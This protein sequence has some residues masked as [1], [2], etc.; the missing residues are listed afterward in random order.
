MVV[1]LALIAVTT[2]GV[3]WF[4]RWQGRQAEFRRRVDALQ[5]LVAGG[6]RTEAAALLAEYKAKSPDTFNAPEIQALAG[7]LGVLEQRERDR[8]AAR[9]RTLASIQAAIDEGTWPRLEFAM[10]EIAEAEKLCTT[11]VERR[12][13]QDLLARL[14]SGIRQHQ[15]A[16][17]AEF[18][19]LL[20]ELGGRVARVSGSDR[21]TLAA[22]RSE[23]ENLSNM[24]RVAPELRRQTQPLIERLS[25]LAKGQSAREQEEQALALVT[26]SIGNLGNYVAA[27]DGYAKSFPQ[28]ARAAAFTR[29][30]PDE[31]PLW[32]AVEPWNRVV[33]RWS[34]QDYRKLR[35]EEAKALLMEMDAAAMTHGAFPAA[36]QLQAVRPYLEAVQ[37]RV[38]DAGE[39]VHKELLAVLE[40]PRVKD[41]AML[42]TVEKKRY[43]FAETDQQA[44]AARLDQRGPVVRHLL[45]GPAAAG[46]QA[47]IAADDPDRQPATRTDVRLGQPAAA[48]LRAGPAAACCA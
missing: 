46:D 30:V 28:T 38:N 34:Q 12:E 17:N 5:Q 4:I 35:P 1:A 29:V 43:Y 2:G 6:K 21:T 18:Q 22:L 20:G 33:A 13:V 3:F 11:D 37:R 45:Q 31:Q 7:E 14:R 27:L 25:T 47:H 10:P 24:P 44:A 40:D 23:A 42:T 16:K 36:A 26:G 9:E 48:D 41:L 19:K 32:N 39:R 8:I 15:D